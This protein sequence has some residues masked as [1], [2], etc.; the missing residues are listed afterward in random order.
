MAFAVYRRLFVDQCKRKNK[1][2][3]R[4]GQSTGFETLSESFG[5]LEELWIGTELAQRKLEFLPLHA[6]RNT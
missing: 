4:E 2:R 1:K 6:G 3:R 5:C